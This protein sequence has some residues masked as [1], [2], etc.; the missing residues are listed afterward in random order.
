[1]PRVI[2]ILSGKGGVGKTTL[3]AN[4]GIVLSNYFKKEI[5]IVDC[6]ITTSHLGLY[7]GM[8]Y[9]PIT[10]NDVLKEKVRLHDA[11]Y[12]HLSGLKLIPASLTLEDM[13]GI[14]IT[15]LTNVL[16]KINKYFGKT[17]AVILD[18]APGLGR[19]AMVTLKASDEVIFVTTPYVPSIVDVIKLRQVAEEMGINIFGIVLNMI[20]KDKHELS[21]KEVEELTELPVISTIPFNKD[22]L[23]SL[24]I[25]VPVSLLYPNSS[26]TKEFKKLGGMLIGEDYKPQTILDKIVSLFFHP[27]PKIPTK[28]R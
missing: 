23:K 28:T 8:Y 1:M 10:L 6:N 13:K 25:R 15:K 3:V 19:D 20:F 18:S 14:D 7:L 24:S 22:V 16:H 26:V 4:L 11:L 5:I 27:K 17:D 2:G 9:C 12:E 21:V